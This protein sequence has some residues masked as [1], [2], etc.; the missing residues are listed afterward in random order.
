MRL[1]FSVSRIFLCAAIVLMA[2]NALGEWQSHQIRHGDGK[3]GWITLPAQRQLLKHPDCEYTM[4]FGLVRMDNGEVVFQGSREKA[5][6]AGGRIFEP[7]IAFS[8]DEGASWS[9]FM[10]IPGTKGRPQFLEWLGG[11][12]LSFI[13]EVF[14]GSGAKRIFSSDYGRTWNEVVDQPLTKD[15]HGFGTEGNGWVDRDEKGAVKAI[16]EIGYYLEAGKSHPTGD[17]TGVFRRS[18]DGGKTWIDEVSP[19]QWKFTMDNNGKQWLRGVSEGSVVRA[20]NGDL[21]AALRTDMPPKYFDGPNDDSLEGTAISISTDD[22]KTWSEM[23]F[24][25]Y[26]GRHHANLQRL[27]N[28]DLVCTVI[29]RDDI[30]EGKLTEGQLTSRRRGCDAVISKDNGKTWNLDRR[31]ELGGFDYMREDGYWVD[32]KVGHL[33][34]VALPN[35]YM[36]CV[37]GDYQRGAT[38]IKW[39]PDAKPVS[40]VSKVGIQIG[41][42]AGPL[43]QYAAEELASYLDKLFHIK[44]KPAADALQSAEILLLIGT[45]ATNPAV[46]QALGNEGWPKVSDQGIVLKKAILDGRPA[47]VIGGG[48][49]AA[50]LWAV[51]DLVE[52]WGV[53][54]LLHRDVLPENPGPFRFPDSDVVL[55]PN[56]RVRQWRTVN[57][58]A[59]G[60]E[61]WGLEEHCRMINQLAKLRFNRIFVS[62][63]PYQ[64]FLDLEYKGIRRTSATLWYDYRFPI[65]EDMPGRKLFGDETEFWNPDLPARGAPY[66]QF[67]TAGERLIQGIFAHAKS[68]GMQCAMNAILTEFPPEFAP[69]LPDSEKVMQ[70]GAM[71]VVPGPKTG[72]DDPAVTD[73]AGAVLQKIL[74]AY[75]DVDYLL[76]GMPEHRQWTGEYERA[77]QTLDNKYHLNETIK[78]GDVVAAAQRRVDYPGGAERA[79]KEVKGDIVSLYFYD[80]LFTDLKALERIDASHVKIIINCAAEELFPI[81][82]KIL[83][84]GSETLNFVDYTPAR[85]LKRREVLGQIPA[86]D[87]PTS[88]IYTLHDDNVGL[89]PMLSTGSLHEITKDLRQYGWSGFSTR[90]WLIGDHDP[91]VAYL[92]RAAWDA[93]ATPDAVYRDQVRAVCG[94]NCVDDMLEVFREVGAATVALE[95]N[96][97]GFTF[98][99]PEMITQQWQ[100]APLPEALASVRGNYERAL[101][102]AQHAQQKCSKDG[103]A[104]VEYWIG[105]LKFGI[106]Y[107]DDVQAFRRAAISDKEGRNADALRE[108]LTARDFV[109]S[110]LEAYANVAQDQSDRGAIATMDEFVYR[111]IERKA[112][113]LKK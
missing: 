94:E 56:L 20:A 38:L 71:S 11:G 37:Y 32:G 46:A 83:P 22:G 10:T 86:R 39:K 3:G 1:Q 28:N 19:P 69:L 17:F 27:P 96:G 85:I 104:Y 93:E 100:A 79:V 48:S 105:R 7:I 75:K 110:A 50:T 35:G 6:P 112:A 47:F 106:G 44:A 91:C 14:D 78:L 76:L 90:Y 51:Y 103:K 4:P 97:L 74:T 53:R 54:Y 57:D 21:V 36:L 26:A 41:P 8:K 23:N 24:L 42:K 62:V 98:A 89:V 68:R 59:C 18:L 80:R 64:P 63:W 45:P 9:E 101:A 25:F 55:E 67:A 34:A 49:D 70:L 61:S 113:E 13:T 107:F 108:V 99:V 73:L 87:L 77:W 40:T 15:G 30:Q 84:Q 33:G 82:P 111:A 65:T 81:L 2:C 102:A 72:V 88:L 16:L 58:F 109:R 52:R 60:P 29:V 12:R 92:A 5:D 43:E 66:E 31:Y 95:W